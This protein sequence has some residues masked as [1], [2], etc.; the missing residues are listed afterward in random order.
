MN[1]EEDSSNT[2]I[3]TAKVSINNFLNFNMRAVLLKKWSF[4]KNLVK[5][6]TKFWTN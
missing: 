3:N 1:L 5:K 6:L 2:L 4:I